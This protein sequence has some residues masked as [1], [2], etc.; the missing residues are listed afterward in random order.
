MEILKQERPF[1]I[2]Q[3]TSSEGVHEFSSHN[4]SMSSIANL[5][6][7]TQGIMKKFSEM[8]NPKHPIHS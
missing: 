7:F 2:R 8:E 4:H 1:A 6:N 5:F 3:Q